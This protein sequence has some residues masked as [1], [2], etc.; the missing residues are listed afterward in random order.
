MK[1][2]LGLEF[3]SVNNTEYGV[4]G[5]VEKCCHSFREKKI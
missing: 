1:A 4:M 2:E 3:W 5:I